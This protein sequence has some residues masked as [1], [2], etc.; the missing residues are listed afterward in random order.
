MPKSFLPIEPGSLEDLF[1]TDELEG[2]DANEGE[3]GSD[4][5]FEIEE[6]VDLD[7]FEVEDAE[8]S[9]PGSTEESIPVWTLKCNQCYAVVN[10]QGMRVH[11]VADESVQLYSA[12]HSG[13]VEEKGDEVKFSTC[14]CKIRKTCCGACSQEVGYRVTSPCSLCMSAQ[15]NGHYW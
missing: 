6:P 11:L 5:D 12:N 15:N 4:P 8:G 1:L 10:R 14:D 9:I 2:S 3:D 13:E 7:E